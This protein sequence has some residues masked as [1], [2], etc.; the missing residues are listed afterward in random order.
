VP[1]PTRSSLVKLADTSIPP[2]RGAVVERAPRSRKRLTLTL[3]LRS[4]AK[5][6]VLEKTLGDITAGRRQPLTHDEFAAQFGMAPDDVARIKRFARAH[7]FRVSLVHVQRRTLHLTGP[8]S[9]LADAFGVDRVRYRVGTLTWESYRGYIHVPYW[10]ANVITGVFG[11]DN[12]PQAVRGADADAA[13]P[14]GKARR[15]V[16]Y[17][18]PEVAELYAFPPGVDGRGQRV[19]VIALGGGYLDSD[20]RTF[21][22]ALKVGRPHFTAV[23]VCGARNAP[24]GSTAGFDGEVTGD[25]ET[26]GA[27]VPGARISVFFAP[28]TTRG[29][30]EAIST[31]VHDRTQNISVLSISW[32]QAEVHWARRTIH[33]V[34][35]MLLEGAVLGVTVCCASGDHGSFADALDREPHVCFPASS[36]YVL[37]CGGTTL[38]GRKSRIDSESVWHNQDGASGGGVSVVFPLPPWQKHSR[39]PRT[40]DGRRGRGVPDVAS[41]A[42]PKT[43]YR[44][45]GH[46]HWHVGAGTSA[47][48]PLWA[49][50]VARI[51]QMRGT[52]AGLI[53]PHLYRDYSRLIR[54][55]ALHSITKGS[56]GTYRARRGWDCCTGNGTPHGAKLADMFVA[57]PV[58]EVPRPR[59][60]GRRKKA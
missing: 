57:R 36:P 3:R 45:F 14:T 10:L 27:L 5:P 34:N 13:T 11:F 46:G 39:V 4:R 18:P 47:A 50:L 6:G 37:A 35:D 25:I 16:S 49:G 23:S 19:G 51:N 54:R 12:R 21:F 7:G 20:L 1:R 60:R 43:G 53:T 24:R 22:R 56:N 28:N 2:L 41:N 40:K 32:G 30:M 26:I 8:T 52:R 17:T 42:D 55:G 48:A 29:F 58:A 15:P 44:I 59:R 33:V 9:K 31:A 38:V